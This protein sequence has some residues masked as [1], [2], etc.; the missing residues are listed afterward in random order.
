MSKMLWVPLVAFSGGSLF[1]SSTNLQAF[2][3]QPTPNKQVR[4]APSATPT[5]SRSTASNSWTPAVL[6]HYAPP[7]EPQEMSRPAALGPYALKVSEKTFLPTKNQKKALLNIESDRY[8]P[9]MLKQPQQLSKINAACTPK[10][11]A[12]ST[13]GGNVGCDDVDLFYARTGYTPARSVSFGKL[14]SFSL[15]FFKNKS[16]TV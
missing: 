12:P 2:A 13:P 14:Y 5:V 16:S 4:F 1:Q 11:G 15:S 6:E 3:Y 9:S 10:Y 8:A 7:T